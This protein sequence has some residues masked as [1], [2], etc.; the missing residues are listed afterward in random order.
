MAKKSC[1]TSSDVALSQAATKKNKPASM[2]AQKLIE[3]QEKMFYSLSKDAEFQKNIAGLKRFDR[4]TTIQKKYA[5]NGVKITKEK[6]KQMMKNGVTVAKMPPIVMPKPPIVVPGVAKPPLIIP[7]PPPKIVSVPKEKVPKALPIKPIPEEL[8]T[9]FK[10]AKTL[11][12][13]MGEWQ[14]YGYNKDIFSDPI[15]KDW[16]QEKRLEV[17]NKINV[18]MNSMQR[19]AGGRKLGK[20]EFFDGDQKWGGFAG[21][22]AM[23]NNRIRINHRKEFYGYKIGE[24][25]IGSLRGGRIVVGANDSSLVLRHEMGHALWFDSKNSALRLE[26]TEKFEGMN[27]ELIARNI[28]KY[29]TTNSKEFFAE[30]FSVYSSPRYQTGSLNKVFGSDFEEL[31]EKILIGGA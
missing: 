12:E 17:M 24:K 23:K 4:V 8:L 15:T 29:A 6:I 5:A 14:K 28:S 31:M 22:T 1:L 7:K 18:Q 19:W 9:E 30:T 16:T 25:S 20:L 10:K 13:A 2:D 3:K 27:K 26:W 21:N 11:D